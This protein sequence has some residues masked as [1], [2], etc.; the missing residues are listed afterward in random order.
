MSIDYMTYETDRKDL[1]T[2]WNAGDKF[3]LTGVEYKGMTGGTYPK[4]VY[5]HG[6]GRWF[7][8]SAGLHETIQNMDGADGILGESTPIAIEAKEFTTEDNK[9]LKYYSVNG[10]TKKQSLEYRNSKLSPTQ[11]QNFSTNQFG[12][13]VTEQLTKIN[14]KLDALQVEQSAEFVKINTT[15]RGAFGGGSVQAEL[16]E[17]P[18]EHPVVE[19]R[20]DDDIPF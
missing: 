4:H 3:D 17:K 20:A 19:K 1:K 15:L 5:E 13:F 9:L 2:V 7:Y 12:K 16:G 8:A 10:M 18:V 11:E 14:A 6:A